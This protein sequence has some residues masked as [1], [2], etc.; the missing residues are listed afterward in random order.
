MDFESLLRPETITALSVSMG[1]VIGGIVAVI[2]EF[3]RPDSK[4]A[5][6]AAH[7]VAKRV[8]AVGDAK[9]LEN[10]VA[11]REECAHLN[12]SIWIVEKKLSDR[13]MRIEAQLSVL[14]GAPPSGAR[15][16]PGRARSDPPQPGERD[17]PG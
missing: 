10:V 6:D 7:H 14:A 1:A 4:D 15:G 5:A 16:G 13:L 2:A 9:R 8:E 3:R 11:V 12:R 17:G